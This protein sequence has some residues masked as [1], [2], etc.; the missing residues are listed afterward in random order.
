MLRTPC[1]P[2]ILLAGPSACATRRAWWCTS[3]SIAHLVAGSYEIAVGVPCTGEGIVEV[4]LQLRHLRR[5]NV[6]FTS[7]LPTETCFQV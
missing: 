1:G 5:A 6:K 4:P 7:G 3:T 2:A